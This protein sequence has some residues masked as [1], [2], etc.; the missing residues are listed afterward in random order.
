MIEQR[1]GANIYTPPRLHQDQ[2]RRHDA[3]TT[4]PFPAARELHRE[5][6][7]SASSVP[8]LHMFWFSISSVMD[9]ICNEHLTI[10]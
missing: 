10:L 5:P 4:G 7:N 3:E 8:Y 1:V 2:A 6:N 9:P